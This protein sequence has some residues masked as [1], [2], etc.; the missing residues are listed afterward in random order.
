MSVLFVLIGVSLAMAS[1]AL[2]A[3]VW[4][5]R[6]GQMDDLAAPGERILVDS[7]GDGIS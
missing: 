5:V 3:F 2:V 6:D 4:S 7:E 1:G